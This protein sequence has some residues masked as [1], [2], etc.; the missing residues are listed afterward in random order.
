MSTRKQFRNPIRAIRIDDTDRRLASAYRY[1]CRQ[2]VIHAWMRETD[3]E[4]RE[5]LRESRV[6]RLYSDDRGEDFDPQDRM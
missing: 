6:E 3:E 1:S 4:L 2:A 5:A